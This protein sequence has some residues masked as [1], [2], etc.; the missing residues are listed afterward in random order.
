MSEIRCKNCGGS[1]WI[2]IEKNLIVCDSCGARQDL[3]TAFSD[4]TNEHIYDTET[5]SQT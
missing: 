2:D 5:D 4:N 3:R 1:I